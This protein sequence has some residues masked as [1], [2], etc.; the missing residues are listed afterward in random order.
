M[1][2]MKKHAPKRKP[3]LQDVAESLLRSAGQLRY[4]SHQLSLA[5]EQQTAS[6]TAWA[7]CAR[8]IHAAV[9][10]LK[11]PA[12][13]VRAKEGPEMSNSPANEGS[14]SLPAA[15]APRE[16]CFTYLDYLELRAWEFRKFRAMP[17]ITEEEIAAVDWKAVLRKLTELAAQPES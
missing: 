5:A 6:A 17:P 3:K 14:T 15:D 12:R 2:P 4:A 8:K 1:T 9:E 16:V 7:E 10:R 13:P 11:R